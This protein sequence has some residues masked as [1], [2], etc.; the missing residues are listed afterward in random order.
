M[1]GVL[2]QGA[3]ETDSQQMPREDRQRGEVQPQDRGLMATA[4]DPE[5]REGPC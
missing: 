5:V 3:A 4:R 2:P 1:V